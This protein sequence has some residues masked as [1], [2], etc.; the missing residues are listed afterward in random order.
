[1]L[2]VGLLTW[3][4]VGKGSLYKAK[5]REVGM[6][7]ILARRSRLGGAGSCALGVLAG[8]LSGSSGA[9]AGPRLAPPL[10]ACFRWHYSFLLAS[11]HLLTASVWLLP[12]YMYPSMDQLA[13]M[14]PGVLHQF[15]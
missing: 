2:G 8:G 7:D 12:R 5:E 6:E 4:A 13:E 3:E 1:M 15:G 10:Q 14:L 9:W 11:G